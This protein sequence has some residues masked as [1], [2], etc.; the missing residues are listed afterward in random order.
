MMKTH[1]S[2]AA[3]NN[4]FEGFGSSCKRLIPSRRQRRLRNVPR[5]SFRPAHMAARQHPRLFNQPREI[6]VEICL[7]AGART[8]R[9][10]ITRRPTGSARA[11]ASLVGARLARGVKRFA[12]MPLRRRSRSYKVIQSVLYGRWSC[13][14]RKLAWTESTK[15]K[16]PPQ[17][18][19]R[20]A[21]LWPDGARRGRC[22]LPLVPWQ[23][24]RPLARSAQERNWD[25]ATD[26]LFDDIHAAERANK[27]V[28]VPHIGVILSAV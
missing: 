18:P 25:L 13:L 6:N 22:S 24:L 26:C 28:H 1:V 14:K 17:I 12:K 27:T 8:F 3:C 9:A 11:A 21:P 19:S 7:D 20:R 16:E 4:D 15:K 5:I 23:P 10:S 2:D